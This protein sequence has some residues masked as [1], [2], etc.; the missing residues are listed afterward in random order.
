MSVRGLTVKALASL[1][2]L[3]GGLLLW[4]SPALA[5][6]RHVFGGTFGEEGTGNGQFKEPT[7]IAV[8]DT[9]H[10]V[11]VVDSTNN[12]VEEFTSTGAYIGQFNGSAAPTGPFQG[13]TWI[14]IDNS[15]NPLDPSAGDVYVIDSGHGV[16]D[17]FS[18]TGVYEGQLPTGEGGTP[19]DLEGVAV[20]PVGVVWVTGGGE[21]DSFSDALVNTPISSA[22]YPYINPGLGVNSN[23][24]LYMPQSVGGSA[25]PNVNV[26]KVVNGT[27]KSE[28]EIEDLKGGNVSDIAVDASDNEA[29]VASEK[30]VKA[31]NE[32]EHRTGTEQ[33]GSGDLARSS[34]IAVD[35]STHWVY[36]VD[37]GADRVAIF[38]NT[39]LPDVV[40]GAEPTTLEHEGSLA[41]TGT[42][43]PD[44]EPITSCQFEYGTEESYGNVAPCET[45][46][47]SGSSPV[48]VHAVVS[49]LTPLTIYHYRL[50]AGNANGS[51]AGFDRTLFAPLRPQIAEESVID[52]TSD[53]AE[54]I[55][56][57][58]PGGA[59]TTYRFEYGPT[60]SYG[61]SLSG[62]AGS[63]TS[64]V[65]ARAPL[66]DLQP[67][68]TYHYRVVVG[69]AV[70]REVLGPDETFSTQAAG[71]EFGLPDGRMWELVTPPDKYGAGLWPDGFEQGSIIQAAEDG[72]GI[73]YPA[74]GPIEVN[75]QGSRSSELTQV[76]STRD[77]P[78]S[79]GTL[80]IATAHDEGPS[81]L[82]VGHESE[83]KLFSSNLSL[84]LVEPDGDTP[85]PPLA[86]GS[87]KTIYLRE[88]G[89]G[90]DALV[91]AA[92]VAPGTKFG[93][94]G[95]GAGGVE[96]INATPDFSH[97][98]ISPVA[99]SATPPGGGCGYVMWAGGDG[100]LT[101]IGGGVL[102]YRH[103]I[104]NDGSRVI[105]GFEGHEGLDLHD[106]ASGETVQVDAAQGVPQPE[107]GSTYRTANGAG[108]RVF[109]TNPGQLT[110]AA[111]E[112]G[113]LYVFEV[114]SGGGE[115]LAG[116]LTDLTV[117]PNAGEA[118]NVQGVIGAS[119]DGSD[120]Y[121]VATGVLGDGAAHGAQSGGDNLYVEEYDEGTKAWASPT[122]IAT[123]SQGDVTSWAGKEGHAEDTQLEE[124]TARVSPNGRY[125]AFMSERSLTGYE[126]RDA[127]SGLPDEEVFLYDASSG[128]L[129][130]ASCDPTGARPVGM[131]YENEP[132]LSDFAQLWRGRW[133]AASVPG[134]DP[135]SLGGISLYQ[136]RYLSNT[137]RLFFDSSDALV[138]GD[139]NGKEDV[140]EFEPAGAGSCQA[141]GYGQSASDVFSEGAGG[142]VALI[143]VGTSPEESVFMDASET[144]GDVFFMTTS[145]LSPLDYDAS[146]D[147]Y[148][149]HECTASAPCAPPPALVPPPCTTGDACKPAPTPQPAI[150]GA[151]A[152]ETFSGAGNIVPSGSGPAVTPRSTGQAQKLAK[153]L[154]ACRKRDS[155]R[156]R[157]RSSCEA[158]ARK[159]Y[160]AKAS[161]HARRS[162]VTSPGGTGGESR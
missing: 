149:A 82:A 98:V 20:D 71:G 51:T 16:I 26:V 130:C 112:G 37:A 55:A 118:A 145:R 90:Y 113:G 66:Q 123:L 40:T 94:N 148:D 151:P 52:V 142:C 31:Y 22:S 101:C 56:Q 43:N 116:R 124:M 2:V 70:Q 62:D 54:L 85:L 140:Y 138:P 80:D 160:G 1:C 117:D 3:T 100:K 41:L 27:T 154:K 132:P 159:R 57:V 42:V 146:M 35:S 109:F 30:Q 152:S 4:S 88:A 84:G 108:S 65:A 89:G 18:A 61:T 45:T 137:G 69:S 128:H 91:T 13:P 72:G 50:V 121:F 133:V 96:M 53:G 141:P 32:H 107:T 33:F 60:T 59:G 29:Y 150:F 99:L 58:D 158:K 24:L 12:R 135:T 49:G 25:G 6:N 77:A 74:T 63:G 34:G 127:N 38:D 14:A 64:A 161:K 75:P 136:P 139:V 21:I 125:L 47:G 144:G 8:N 122:F 110:T 28:A 48:A 153:A 19:S 76:I 119:E 147:I 46:P 103:A 78:G 92:N 44:G 115:R 155:S 86:P 79:W 10:D 105:G 97:V 68:T 11:Y 162:S 93:G 95:E 15:G 73:T 9:T 102:P 36:V 111:T 114:T 131:T 7:G 156:R 83:Y 39:I 17:K 126:N 134:W 120:V 104:S 106:M 81:T 143:S 87:E 23:D 5:L 157:E 67:D 129:A